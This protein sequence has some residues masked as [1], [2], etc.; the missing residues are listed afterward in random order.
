MNELIR[1]FRKLM[2][3]FTVVITIIA[4][5]SIYLPIRNELYNRTLDNF[6]LESKEQ[7]QVI[8]H[9]MLRSMERTHILSNRSF[10]KNQIIKYYDD[11]I[12]LAQLIRTT[13]VNYLESVK[14]IEYV[15][16]AYR[17]VDNK[18]TNRF[19]ISDRKQ[20]ILMINEIESKYKI[21]VH[22]ESMTVE[23]TSPIL[24]GNKI[25][26]Y[27][28]ICFNI[29]SIVRP[30]GNERMDISLITK[31][32]AKKVTNLDVKDVKAHN[33][34]LKDD[35][36]YTHLVRKLETQDYYYYV[37]VENY[38]LFESIR[39]ISFKNIIVF[40]SSIIFLVL[41]SNWI[42]IKMAQRILVKTERSKD[43]Y[44][45]YATR[46]SLTGV[47]SRFFL[48]GWLKKNLK[49]KIHTKDYY[50]VV[51][52]DIDDFKK[53]NDTY[54]HNVGDKTVIQVANIL[55]SSIREGDFVIRYGGDEFLLLMTNLE[56]SVVEIILERITNRL[57]NLNELVFPISISYG[58]QETKELSE[59]HKAID[60][61]DERMYTE[62][63]RKQKLRQS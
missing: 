1:E 24:E 28:V 29:D 21:Q 4:Y 17:V 45:E 14:D 51:M 6:V 27:D 36:T 10:L 60:Q 49:D 48:E 15:S 56:L 22:N 50:T 40:S 25:L 59:L 5:F 9:F 62:K 23:I 41:V 30:I 3:I 32:E 39:E 34:T 57:E 11:K 44:K 35:G 55:K 13:E 47:Y 8:E 42:T 43:K 61:A 58:I 33:M 26:G 63:K 16:Y 31:E 54:G 46:D 7:G 20:P 53:I 2:V 19:M 52:I 18:L 38:V 12:D 37:K